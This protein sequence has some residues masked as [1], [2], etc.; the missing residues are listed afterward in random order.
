MKT[1]I[2]FENLEQ[3]E[4]NSDSISVEILDPK[5][6]GTNNSSDTSGVSIVLNMYESGLTIKEI[7]RLNLNDI[8]SIEHYGDV[9]YVPWH[10][11]DWNTNR[12]SKTEIKNSQVLINI[13]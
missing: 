8:V 7:A 10:E 4:V 3:I 6:K 2:N 11:E 12:F 13:D 5:R 1:E 9:I